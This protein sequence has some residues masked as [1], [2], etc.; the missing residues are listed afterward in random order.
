MDE[1]SV[2]QLLDFFTNK[3]LL[4]HRLLLQVLAHKLHIGV[5]QEFVLNHLARDL[6]YV[7]WL[8]GRHIDIGQEER[9]KL[10]FLF[11]PQPRTDAG[12][13]GGIHFNLKGLPG[14]GVGTVRAYVWSIGLRA[15]RSSSGFGELG[16]TR[17]ILGLVDL[18]P[19]E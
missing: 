19:P 11:V 15:T 18:G 6:I 5:D 3:V 1:V 13:P 9:D 16:A 4:L 14:H 10:K 12:G 7:R 8:P 2:E 17:A